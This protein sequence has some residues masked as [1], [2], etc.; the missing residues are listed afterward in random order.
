MLETSYALHIIAKIR[1]DDMRCYDSTWDEKH[2]GASTLFNLINEFDKAYH[3]L[4]SGYDIPEYPVFHTVDDVA[5]VLQAKSFKYLKLFDR[6]VDMLVS[7]DEYTREEYDNLINTIWSYSHHDDYALRIA[8]ILDPNSVDKK[9][10]I[11]DPDED[12]VIEEDDDD[13][14]DND[15]ANSD[16][17]TSGD[18]SD[19]DSNDASNAIYFE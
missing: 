13:N 3:A 5:E 17:N 11:V 9:M 1:D 16:N 10:V 12:K 4:H 14:D 6:F 8:R 18:E 2:D 15:A 7:N 19:G